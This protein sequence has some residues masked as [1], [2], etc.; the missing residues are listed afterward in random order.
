M[1]TFVVRNS[2]AEIFENGKQLSSLQSV[3]P[4]YLN[5]R[6]WFG[7]KGE[8]IDSLT[9]SYAAPL[10]RRRNNRVVLTEV[11]ARIGDRVENYVLPLCA[12]PESVTNPIVQQ[13][14]LSR[15]RRVALVGFLTD[16]FASDD[17]TIAL[18][19]AIRREERIAIPDG[20]LRFR[21]GPTFDQ[22][23]LPEPLQIRRLSAEQSNSSQIIS[24]LLVLKIIRKVLAGVHPEGE[25]TGYLTERGFAN[26][27]PLFGEVVRVSAD[28]TPHTLL[29]LQGFVRNQGDGWGWTLDYLARVTD[30]IGMQDAPETP[31]ALD[32]HYEG[33]R[34]LSTA[35]GKRL[36]ELHD[37]LSS[38]TDNPDFA[39]RVARRA[40]LQDWADGAIAQ[41]DGAIA[42]LRRFLDGDTSATEAETIEMADRTV[43]RADALRATVRRLAQHGEGALV[44]RVHGDFHLGQVLVVGADAYL[45]DFEGEPAKSMPER[46]AHS[47][48]LRDVAGMMR[49]FDYAA[50]SAEIRARAAPGL[51]AE[52]QLEALGAFRGIAI[53]SFASAYDEVLA[54][55]AHPWVSEDAKAALLDL[56]LIE[57]ASYEIRYEVS[58][59]PAWLPIPLRGL[60]AIATRLLDV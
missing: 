24:D 33:Y 17:F 34:P 28:G 26:T 41:L 20:E 7:S 9:I 59:R 4:E 32:E 15:I 60:D 50:S 35:I 56:F 44:T 53:T 25:V 52:R 57:K 3:L 8:A 22:L 43:A 14:A 40:D 16:G 23:D 13:L 39:P 54:A 29:L 51:G 27:A 11:S 45:I 36:A 48:P 42:Q 12:V 49:S 37:V 10:D 19:D 38:P 30:D 5:K 1:Q 58:N 47:C 31:Q 21:K 55:S 6:R 18:L 46:R 2:V